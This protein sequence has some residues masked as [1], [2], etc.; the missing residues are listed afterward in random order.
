[1]VFYE[2]FIAFLVDIYVLTPIQTDKQLA[3][4]PEIAHRSVTF[5]LRRSTR[6]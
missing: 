2:E 4:Y 5:R 6:N 3:V 1:M